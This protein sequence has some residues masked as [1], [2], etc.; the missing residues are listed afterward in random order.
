MKLT[1]VKFQGF[2]RFEEAGVY[3]DRPVVALVGPNEAGKTSLLHALLSIETTDPIR[4]ED[5]SRGLGQAEEF[6]VVTVHYS[7]TDEETALAAEHG[8]CGEP[9]WY[10]VEKYEDG[11][12]RRHVDPRVSKPSLDHRRTVRQTIENIFEEEHLTPVLSRALNTESQD[13]FQRQALTTRLSE[14]HRVM[15]LSDEQLSEESLGTIQHL[16]DGIDNSTSEGAPDPELAE[17][18]LKQ[19]RETFERLHSQ[20]AAPHPQETL[21][22]R[23]EILRPRFRFFGVEDRTLDSE[24]S[25]SVLSDPPS[26]LQNLLDLA[27]LSATA[28]RMAIG[29]NDHGQRLALEEA[30][31]RRLEAACS[32]AWS[33]S[34][35]FVR[36]QVDESTIRIHANAAEAYRPIVEGSDGLRTFAALLAFTH[37]KVQDATRPGPIILVDEAETHLH[38]DAQAD[39]IDLFYRQEQAPQVIYSTHSAGCLPRDLGTDVRVVEA[40]TDAD[41]SE[42]DRSRIRSDFWNA[43]AGYSPLMLAMGASVFAL[44]PTRFAVLAE[45]VS[46]TILLPAL[47]RE[48]TES[49]LLEFQVAPGLATVSRADARLLD[50]EAPRVAYCVDGDEGGK[51]I[52]RKLVKGGVAEADIARLPTGWVLEDLL[53]PSA[54]AGAINEELS[55]W[56]EHVRIKAA[57]LRGLGRPRKLDQ[58]CDE[59][60]VEARP[61]KARVA[62]S[63]A[64]RARRGE[65]LL[66]SKGRKHLEKLDGELRAVLGLDEARA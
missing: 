41:G 33:Q 40:I 4:P 35:F 53:K 8:G 51:A 23:L 16:L 18:Q 48:A 17:E 52:A 6:P 28:M 54:Y 59:N 30:A 7:L 21:L 12:V 63:L 15:E 26:S 60:G 2:R 66:S 46:E 64:D 9:K 14:V 58:W 22:A 62:Q 56:G 20:E 29:T 44:S 47:L 25:V 10:I 13:Q 49:E 5:R 61:A 27:G 42:T 34:D 1:K 31:N 65:K 11:T 43:G 50:R 37:H 24:Y 39:L 36:L 19:L 45:G 3:L 55:L 32:K 57:D 38:Y